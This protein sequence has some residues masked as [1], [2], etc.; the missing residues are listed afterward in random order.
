MSEDKKYSWHQEVYSKALKDIAQTAGA[1][2]N[3]SE[4]L[5]YFG[6]LEWFNMTHPALYK[7]YADAQKA[8]LNLW[9]NKDPKAME[10][11]KAAVKI[12]VDATKWA[13]E[14]YLQWQRHQKEVEELKGT[15]GVLV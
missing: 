9:D 3:D 15:Q 1:L 5:E 7:K 6:W 11:F 4:S 2:C 12:E 8:I 13:V 14:K 10:E